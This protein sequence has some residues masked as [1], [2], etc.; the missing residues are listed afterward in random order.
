MRCPSV[1]PPRTLELRINPA[2]LYRHKRCS[3]SHLNSCPFDRTD[4]PQFLTAG[5][6]RIER[7]CLC[8]T[9]LAPTRLARRSTSSRHSSPAVFPT[10]P[11]ALRSLLLP[12]SPERPPQS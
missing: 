1:I 12:A 2:F 3:R 10:V 7:R 11:V 5:Q 8:A 4:T 6:P 9:A